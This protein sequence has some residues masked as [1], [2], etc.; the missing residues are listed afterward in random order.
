MQK[1]IAIQI[2]KETGLPQKKPDRISK[3]NYFW[4]KDIIENIL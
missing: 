3:E 4:I 1:K 2:K